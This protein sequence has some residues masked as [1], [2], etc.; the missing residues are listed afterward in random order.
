M[1]L[2]VNYKI[3]LIIYC[4][5]FSVNKPCYKLFNLNIQTQILLEL[6]ISMN[7]R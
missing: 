1:I 3:E 4:N 2:D 6:L 7:N 5:F